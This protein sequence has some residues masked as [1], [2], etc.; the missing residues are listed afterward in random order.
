[1]DVSHKVNRQSHGR[2]LGFRGR[3]RKPKVPEKAKQ[4]SDGH[5]K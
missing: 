2:E 1:M 3:L 4:G 5:P